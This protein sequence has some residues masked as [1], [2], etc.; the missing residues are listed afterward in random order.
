MLIRSTTEWVHYF[1]QL[2]DYLI[3]AKLPH[4]NVITRSDL[5]LE[6]MLQ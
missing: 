1:N 5:D 2:D 4:V 3:D 6:D